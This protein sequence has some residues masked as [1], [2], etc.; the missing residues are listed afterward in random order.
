MIPKLI[1]HI[2]LQGGLPERYEENVRLWEALNNQWEQI[3]WD[4]AS[5]L[6]LCS[7]EQKETYSKLVTLINRVNYLKYILM[8]SQGGVYADLD[9]YPLRPLSELMSQDHIKDIDRTAT[10]SI[11]YPFNTHRTERPFSSYDAIIPARNTM[12]FYKDGEKPLLLDNPV[13]MSTQG[14]NIWLRLIDFCEKRTNLKQNG[15]SSGELL[16]HEPYGPY[17]LT[18]FIFNTYDSPFED[19]ILILPPHYLMSPKEHHI[20]SSYIVHMA[21]RG[22]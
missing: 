8:H 6:R 7:H 5:L 9:T 17:G 15:F 13:L 2:W 4:E 3:L 12:F 21:E 1:H 11:R 20:S 22:W 19:G 10:I 14:N 16:P 18:D